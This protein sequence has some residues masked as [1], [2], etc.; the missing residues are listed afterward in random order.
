MPG[1]GQNEITPPEHTLL[2][3]R[4]VERKC[5]RSLLAYQEQINGAQIELVVIW[6]GGKAI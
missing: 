6:Q 2:A 5:K 4:Y 1:L 3:D